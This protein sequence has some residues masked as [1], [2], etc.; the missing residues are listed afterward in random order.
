[1]QTKGNWQGLLRIEEG[2]PERIM[3]GTFPINSIFHFLAGKRIILNIEMIKE[4]DQV[5]KGQL[6]TAGKLEFDEKK[7]VLL[8]EKYPLIELLKSFVNQRVSVRVE[9]DQSVLSSRM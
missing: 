3:V 9:L 2:E 1:M 6:S 4:S 8:L 5:E 7:K